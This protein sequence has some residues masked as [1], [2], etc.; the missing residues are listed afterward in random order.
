MT[1]DN[2]ES[3][4]VA[5]ADDYPR[6]I[7]EIELYEREAQRWHDR[8]RKIEKRYDD[9]RNTAEQQAVRFDILWSNIQTLLPALYA[10]NPKPEFER[11]FL[12]ADP[13][14]RAVSQ[15]L[16]RCVS[17]TLDCVDFKSLMRQALTDRLLPGRG[18]LWVRYV[19]HFKDEPETLEATTPE[20]VEVDD[21]ADATATAA[22]ELDY[23]EVDIDYVHWR[24]FGHTVARTWQDVRGVWRIVYL[25]KRELEKR[26]GKELAARIPLDYEPADMKG[27]EG[28][29]Y[30][31]KARVYE[32][33]D[34]T[35]RRAL[36]LSKGYKDALLDEQD[37]PLGL[38]NFFPCPR[39]MFPNMSNDSLIPV[40]DY[41]H[42]QGQAKEIDDL[43]GRISLLTK[44]IKAAGVYDASSPAIARLLS[45]GVENQLIPV[46]SWGAFGEKGGLKGSMELLPMQD[47]ATTLLDLYKARDAVKQD[48]YEITGM[49]DIIRGATDPNE[50]ATAQQIKSSFGSLRL[51]D[52]KDDVERFARDVVRIVA[53]IQAEHFEL[54]TLA[55]MSGMAL[56]TQA[57]KQIA[58]Q[59]LKFGGT[60]PD[61]IDEAFREAT[62][63][64]VGALLR[65]DGARAFRLDVETDS[66]IKMD[67][68]QEKQDRTDFLKTVGEF[69]QQGM[70]AAESNPLLAPL[71]GD[72]LMFVVRAFPVGRSLEAQIQ[73]TVDAL[74]KQA[75]QAEGQPKPNP[76]TIKAN[77]DA[78]AS[79][80]KANIDAQTK[81]A[82]ARAQ[83]QSDMQ[84][85]LAEIQARERAD[86]ANR[87]AQAQADAADRQA[88]MVADRQQAMLN[89]HLDA[90]QQRNQAMLDQMKM[91]FEGS[92]QM[93]IERLKSQTAIEAA[94]I[95]AG[96]TVDAA[97]VSAAKSGSVQ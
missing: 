47:L 59:I 53:E 49:S 63:E 37:D 7:A 29:E 2:N 30:A 67:E 68:Q 38:S 27:V 1:A 90:V 18:T 88:Q 32:I 60:L 28:A 17:E 40:P 48:L 50:T 15:V 80:Q 41:V 20:S 54:E 83:N 75:K 23:E 42:Y 26:F 74:K 73:S 3:T 33:W 36:W 95:A 8:G 71:M 57:E 66:T 92:L 72:M 10:K 43:T 39:P 25:E 51:D 31:R 70:Q 87:E 45:E 82:V 34:R 12:Q 81:I 89:A 4:P 14:A 69:M 22:P 86:A 52:Q 97:Q 58:A 21:D 76:V 91:Q 79:I 11:R 35:T 5:P 94:E 24:D 44:A 78:Q 96:A 6:W 84:Q 77:A 61:D 16:E 13:V 56:M 62:W 85:N 46:D 55:D 93:A 9:K 65:N 64:E 19:P